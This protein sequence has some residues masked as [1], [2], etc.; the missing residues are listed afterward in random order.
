VPRYRFGDFTLSPRRRVLLRGDREQPLIPRYFDLLVFLVERR[1]D[2][3]H[4]R[5]IF[6]AVWSD[7][8]VSDS[9]LSQAIRTIRR[10]LEDNSREPRFVRTVSRYGYQFVCPDVLE[11]DD[12]SEWPRAATTLSAAVETQSVDVVETSDHFTSLLVQISHR[13]IDPATQEDQREAAEQLHALGTSE[14][15]GRLAGSANQAFARA[16]LRDT[17]WDVAGAGVVPIAGTPHAGAVVAHLV[18]L[19]LARAADLVAARWTSTAAGGAAA[20]AVAGAA[21]GLLLVLVPGSTSPPPAI[22]VLGVVGAAV[23]AVG[24]GGVGA[25]LAT[26]EAVVRSRR[27][28]GLLLG[29]A[30]GGA[31]VGLIVQVLARW[32]LQVLVGITPSIGGCLEGLAIGAA[33][34][35]G[36]GASTRHTTD[37]LAAPSGAARWRVVLST[38]AA[39]ALA[40]LG[41]SLA[42]LPL[43]GGTLNEIAQSSNGAQVA[44]APLG[45]LIGEPGFGPL[46]AASIAS[47]EGA[48]FGAGLALGLTRRP[49]RIRSDQRHLT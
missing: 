30:A 38:S 29:G 3:V 13:Q 42:G 9:A 31:L 4:R 11:E 22:A 16:L 39:C 44:L 18:R 1:G 17:R 34:G 46:T 19:R 28:L 2:A 26:A 21:G 33:A 15:L 49:A 14:A 20:G 5:E 23:G 6:D 40:A 48:F 45:L 35:L 12:G 37:G 43:A 41:L 7:V 8:V 24:G 36:Y 25:G 10:V 47:G 27:A 32:S